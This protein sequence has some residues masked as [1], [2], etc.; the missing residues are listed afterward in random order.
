MLMIRIYSIMTESSQDYFTFTK[1]WLSKKW[2]LKATICLVL[3]RVTSDNINTHEK[4][5]KRKAAIQ[6]LP[7]SHTHKQPR[8]HTHKHTVPSIVKCYCGDSQPMR[9]PPRPR[10]RCAARETSTRHRDQGRPRLPPDDARRAAFSRLVSASPHSLV[11][12]SP[13]QEQLGWARKSSTSLGHLLL[14]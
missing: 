10:E 1:A 8:K 7:S 2:E 11:S 6:T 4:T 5:Y 9:G 12:P 14:L 3:S 13:S